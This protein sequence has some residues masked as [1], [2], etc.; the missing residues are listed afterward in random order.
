[1]TWSFTWTSCAYTT[2]PN[3]LDGIIS[4][5]PKAHWMLGDH[6]YFAWDYIIFGKE[7][8][9]LSVTSATSVWQ[10][11]ARQFFWQPG[12]RKMQ[13]RRPN[14]KMLWASAGDDHGLGGSNWD[15]TPEGANGGAK[16]RI[17][18]DPTLKQA[19]D[20]WV[21]ARAAHALLVG[22]Q[23]GQFFDNPQSF[24]NDPVNADIPAAVYGKAYGKPERYPKAYF[25]TDFTTGGNVLVTA[26]NALP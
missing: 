7:T 5:D 24:T 13:K 16:T 15:H 4:H 17:A 9:Q 14:M 1:M 19:H 12:W 2:Q 3:N 25:Y 26:E 10:E 18:T 22:M 11:K 23:E 21:Q 8:S 6:S 20:H